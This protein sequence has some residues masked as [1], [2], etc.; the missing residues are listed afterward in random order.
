MTAQQAPPPP[1]RDPARERF[2]RRFPQ[3]ARAVEDPDR[4]DTTRWAVLIGVNEHLGATRDNVASRQDAE[5]LAAHLRTL[6]W[7]D[8]H[9]LV[10][11]DLEATREHIVEAFRW[12]ARSTTDGSV[13]VVHYSGHTKQWPGRDVDGDGEVTDEGLWPADNRFITDGEVAT[14]LGA[15]RAAAMWID[16]AACEAAGLADPALI[17]PGRVLT[18]SSA[19]DEKSYEDPE[20]GNSVWGYVVIEEALREGF[21]D[22]DGD[23]V[24]TVEEAFA[25][26]APRAVERTSRQ[27]RGAQHPVMVDRLDGGLDLRVPAPPRPEPDPSPRPS[28]PLVIC[29][30]G[31]R[32]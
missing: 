3:H 1:P 6:G 25:F 13:V 26:A 4:P 2:E 23:R 30:P 12:L 10:L 20:R 15:V 18:L 21:G 29:P 16:V 28:C 8:D 27:P 19:E 22:R 14:L 24:V 7:R 32:R 11:T 17:L 9:V 31:P 5:D